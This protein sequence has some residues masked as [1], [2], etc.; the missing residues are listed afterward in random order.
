MGGGEVKYIP[1]PTVYPGHNSHPT[2]QTIFQVRGA[3]G[4]EEGNGLQC[5]A[6]FSPDEVQRATIR[7]CEG[8]KGSLSLPRISSYIPVLAVNPGH[9]SYP[10]NHLPSKGSY[11]S[12]RRIC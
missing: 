11:W 5:C 3:T 10:T 2:D 4:Q 6:L 1:V 12:G 9:N 7:F 8:E